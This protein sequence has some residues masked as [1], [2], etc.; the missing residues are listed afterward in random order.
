[1]IADIL[2]IRLTELTI[3]RN[4]WSSIVMVSIPNTVT[5]YLLFIFEFLHKIVFLV[6]D[7]LASLWWLCS[8]KLIWYFF[9]QLLIV[10]ENFDLNES[11]WSGFST[12]SYHLSHKS[13]PV[14]LCLVFL[15]CTSRLFPDYVLLCCFFK[16]ATL[17]ALLY[18]VWLSHVWD[19][20]VTT[21]LYHAVLIWSRTVM[22]LATSWHLL[23]GTWSIF[24]KHKWF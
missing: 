4:N 1:M 24:I 19:S 17:R 7:K 21:G 13:M 9:K 23:W 5:S 16:F 12:T 10:F 6:R 8:S 2:P 20:S 18:M 3:L 11:A 15:F 22:Q 14:C